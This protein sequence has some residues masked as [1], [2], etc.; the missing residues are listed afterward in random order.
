MKPVIDIEDVVGENTAIIISSPTGILY[1]AQCD[2]LGCA[3][4]KYEG[5][6]MPLGDFGSDIDDCAFGCAHLSS[7]EFEESRKELAKAIDNAGY[8]YCLYTTM[9]LRFDYSRLDDLKEGWWPMLLDG[10]FY[11]NKYSN[12]PV[13][14]CGG[15]CD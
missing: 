4:M 8:E 11:G 6:V 2:G 1:N 5:Y 3:Q 9:Q 13:I 15:N 12:H 7:P 10:T 14:V